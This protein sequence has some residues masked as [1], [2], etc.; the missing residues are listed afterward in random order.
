MSRRGSFEDV[1]VSPSPQKLKELL[2]VGDP[3]PR[4]RSPRAPTTKDDEDDAWGVKKRLPI[5]DPTPAQSQADE[6]LDTLSASAKAA[7]AKKGK[8]HDEPLDSRVTR[9][10]CSKRFDGALVQK[11]AQQVAQIAAMRKRKAE[12]EAGEGSATPA[13]KA[14]RADAA[15]FTPGGSRP[16]VAAAAAIAGGLAPGALAPEAGEG[17]PR[18]GGGGGDGCFRRGARGRRP[19]GGARRGAAG[20]ER[21]AAGAEGRGRSPRRAARDLLGPR[22]RGRRVM[23]EREDAKTRGLLRYFRRDEKATCSET[24][25]KV[26]THD[27]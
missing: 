26:H 20:A 1:G 3:A 14:L 21:A 4:L 23:D 5:V 11:Y 27:C 17:K 9:H 13:A 16:V 2:S 19:G 6:K 8:K 12:T 25:H 22:G 7:V 15:A 18:G 10:T 24:Y